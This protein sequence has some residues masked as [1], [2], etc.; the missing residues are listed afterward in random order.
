[1]RRSPVLLGR[2]DEGHQENRSPS[3]CSAGWP[4]FWITVLCG[5]AAA[6]LNG[7]V[8]PSIATAYFNGGVDPCIGAAHTSKA[9]EVALAKSSRIGSSFAFAGSVCTF[10]ASPFVALLCDRFGRKPLIIAVQ[11]T[12][13]LQAV[14]LLLVDLFGSSLYVYYVLSLVAGSLCSVVVFSLWIADR[15]DPAQRADQYRSIS[16]N[17]KPGR[18]FQLSGVIFNKK[19]RLLSLLMLVS[20]SV[21]AGCAGIFLYYVKINFGATV[22]DLAPMIFLNG[23]SGA[24]VQ[25]LLVKH[26][27]RWLGLKGV[28]LLGYAFGALNCAWLSF[29]PSFRWLYAL[30][31]TSGLGI[32]FTPA[33]QTVYLNA[34]SSAEMAQVQG[35][36]NSIFTLAGGI[37]PTLFSFLMTS[38]EAPH[39]GLTRSIYW[40]PYVLTIVSNLICSV[41][42]M[43]QTGESTWNYDAA[44]VL[45]AEDNPYHEYADGYSPDVTDP[46]NPKEVDPLWFA[47]LPS[48]GPDQALQTLPE[49]K[50]G[51]FGHDQNMGHWYQDSAGKDIQAYKYPEAYAEQAQTLKATG[52]DIFHLLKGSG[53]KQANW[54]D[55]SVSQYDAYG[56]P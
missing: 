7:L 40:V 48:G 9:C 11:V 44:Q 32:I 17:L 10:F 12:G 47:S 5:A 23:I 22:R 42:V 25:V 35:A 38:F 24:I 2:E 14:T 36:M 52:G 16:A 27:D 18:L 43:F 31:L 45:R 4:A 50:T 21:H 55:A 19:Y 39:F 20:T 33:I 49:P 41:V 34:A 56:R 53:T 8:V 30:S 26:L 28:I 15:T 6:V 46:L 3:R 37:G 13:L 1:M 51:P 29:V 54:F